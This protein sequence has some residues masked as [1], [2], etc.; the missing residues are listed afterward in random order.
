MT[1]EE[2]EYF[3]KQLH[4]MFENWA[5]QHSDIGNVCVA[6]L[7]T[8]ADRYMQSI[9]GQQL[10]PQTVFRAF[11]EE[12]RDVVSGVFQAFK[13]G[14]MVEKNEDGV[15]TYTVTLIHA[16]ESE[17]NADGADCYTIIL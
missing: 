13:A 11:L 8:F 14:A 4:K 12:Y 17:G 5:A 7:D 16:V 15:D 6:Q 9:T 2:R 3:Y 1:R 10:L